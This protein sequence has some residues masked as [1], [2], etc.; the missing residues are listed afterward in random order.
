MNVTFVIVRD[1]ANTDRWQSGIPIIIG[2][3]KWQI[4]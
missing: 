2:L 4:D 3:Q 1:N